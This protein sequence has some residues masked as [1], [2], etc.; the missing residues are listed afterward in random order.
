LQGFVLL[1]CSSAWHEGVHGLLYRSERASH[2]AGALCGSVILYPVSIYRYAH[3]EHHRYTNV[4]GD[5]EDFP[6]YSNLFQYFV[7]TPLGAPIFFAMLWWKSIKTVMGR[8]PPWLRTDRARREVTRSVL[9]LL[10]FLAGLIALTAANPGPMVTFYW[11]PVVL[12]NTVLTALVQMP[13]H[14]GILKGPGPAFTTTRSTTSN[15]IVRW[16]L[17]GANFHA[18]HHLHPGVPALN[19]GRVH[20]YI[21]SR[22]EHVESSYIRWHG[23]VIT[24]LAT[25]RRKGGR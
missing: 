23:R 15:A 8:P 21:E 9:L 3:L 13:E 25:K 20:T 10:L 5:T 16:F 17:W 12:A 2:V 11:A 19:L 22:C 14:Y 1:G 24:E 18:A 7:L 4:D 6:T